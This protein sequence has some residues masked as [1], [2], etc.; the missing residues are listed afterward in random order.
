ML[1]MVSN[2]TGIEVGLLAGQYPGRIGHLFSPGGQRG[3]W[4]ELPY[5]LDNGAWPAFLNDEP[6]SEAEWRNLIAWA[7]ISGIAPLWALVPDVV[8]DRAATLERWAKYEAPVRA[9]GF[10]PAFAVQ[11]GMTF[12]DVPSDDCVLFLGGDDK[13]KDAAIGPWCARYPGRVHVGR[14]NTW[15]RLVACWRAGAISVDGTGWFRKGRSMTN[16]QS[17]DLRK[18]LR[19]T[20]N[21]DKE[22]APLPARA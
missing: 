5:A 7:A 4:R 1:V 12:A 21:A 17:N 10:R 19:E 2:A 20:T 3:P 11:N 13:F 15:G 16:S 14:V 18:F 6:W 9:H 8:G 22:N